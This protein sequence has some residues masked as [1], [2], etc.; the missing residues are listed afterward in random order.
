[1]HDLR[2]FTDDTPVLQLGNSGSGEVINHQIGGC[3]VLHRNPREVAHNHA[4]VLVPSP[5][6]CVVT[7]RA[8]NLA[9]FGAGV[10][11][12]ARFES[13][14]EL[15]KGPTL[16]EGVAEHEIGPGSHLSSSNAQI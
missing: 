7:E 4:C 10:A 6:H 16:L 2:A 13:K 5:K 14:G 9:Y 11:E 12:P 1:M 8:P 15:A 3:N